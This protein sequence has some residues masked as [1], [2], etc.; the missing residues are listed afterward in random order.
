MILHFSHI[1]FTDGRT[2]MIPF[3]S[4]ISE[5]ALAAVKGCRYRSA[6]AR[7]RR[8][9]AQRRRSTIAKGRL[10]AADG[11]RAIAEAFGALR[12]DIELADDF[13]EL[14]AEFLEHFS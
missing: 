8:G 7:A 14:P 2:F 4:V 10:P 9:R 6:D 3:G 11:S 5:P 1:G 13:D 12:G